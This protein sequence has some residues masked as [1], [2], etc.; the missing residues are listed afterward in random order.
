MHEIVSIAI[1]LCIAKKKKKNLCWHY[2]NIDA[3]SYRFDTRCTS[4]FADQ[5]NYA[6]VE[7]DN[8]D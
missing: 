1:T 8:C 2:H 4:Y 6:I 7:S 3:S 5:I